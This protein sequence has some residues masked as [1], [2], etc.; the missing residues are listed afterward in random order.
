MESENRYV[1]DYGLFWIIVTIILY[2]LLF[3]PTVSMLELGKDELNGTTGHNNDVIICDLDN[4]YP[5]RSGIKVNAAFEN[6]VEAMHLVTEGKFY[7]AVA[8]RP[9]LEIASELGL[10]RETSKS[11]VSIEITD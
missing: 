6:N 8:C 10:A 4:V 1:S 5:E 7:I 9:H 11:L 3:I 2:I